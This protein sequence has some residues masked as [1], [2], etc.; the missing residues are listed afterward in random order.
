VLS[1]YVARKELNEGQAITV[2]ENALFH[3][4]NRIYR[5]GLKPEFGWK[6]E[7]MY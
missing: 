6:N 7:Q 5:L 1:D 3:N 4:A 2:V